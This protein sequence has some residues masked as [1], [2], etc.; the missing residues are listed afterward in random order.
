[1][2]EYFLIKKISDT[3]SDIRTL[4]RALKNHKSE[5]LYLFELILG[6][7]L[8]ENKEHDERIILLPNAIRRFLEI[9]TLMK[10]PS[11]T[12]EVDNR[13]KLL[14]PEFLEL[15]TLHH[16]S[17]FTNLEKVTKHDNLIM[18]LPQAV[19]ELMNLLQKDEKHFESLKAGCNPN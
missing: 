18:N 4:P 15:K 19:N 13:L 14:F 11:S 3:V 5:Y 7:H 12:D 17:H 2:S 16:F 1:T 10:L 6:F 9:Y 8:S